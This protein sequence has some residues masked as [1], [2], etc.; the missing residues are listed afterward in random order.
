M[1][2][3]ASRKTEISFQLN[4]VMIILL[5]GNMFISDQGMYN[6]RGHQSSLICAYILQHLPVPVWCTHQSMPIKRVLSTE[7][8]GQ[9]PTVGT[10]RHTVFLNLMYGQKTISTVMAH[11]LNWLILTLDQSSTLSVTIMC[12]LLGHW[13]VSCCSYFQQESI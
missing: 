12:G 4:S 7:Q 8:R 1:M 3:V 9:V 5:T 6:N 13:A 2:V 11:H 10:I